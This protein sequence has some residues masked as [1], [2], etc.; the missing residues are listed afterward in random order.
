MEEKQVLQV[1]FA[2]RMQVC[3][4]INVTVNDL[5][6]LFHF[7]M[8]VELTGVATIL[9]NTWIYVIAVNK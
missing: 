3:I 9:S 4:Y 2:I 1:P 6:T 7:G 5:C 8:H